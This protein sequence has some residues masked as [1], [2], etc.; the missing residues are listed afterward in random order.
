MVNMASTKYE[1]E[2]FNEKKKK[3]FLSLAME[4]VISFDLA[5]S[6]LGVI[7]KGEETREDGQ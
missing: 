4:D 1:V 7:K 3:H 5:M 2:K 6:L